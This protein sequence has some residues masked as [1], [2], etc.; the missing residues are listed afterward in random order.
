MVLNRQSLK[1][2]GVLDHSADSRKAGRAGPACPPL[3]LLA[4]GHHYGYEYIDYTVHLLA[5]V[6]FL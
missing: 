6:G 2:A 4:M 3:G 1:A 5:R